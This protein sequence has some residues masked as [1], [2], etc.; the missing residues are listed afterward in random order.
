[1]SGTWRVLI[2]S[3]H[4]LGT[5]SYRMGDHLKLIGHSLQGGDGNDPHLRNLVVEVKSG[6]KM[7]RTQPFSA[8]ASHSDV[9]TLNQA[10]VRMLRFVTM[11]GDGWIMVN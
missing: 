11:G 6:N 10:A 9:I 4:D 2:E 1:M 7:M 3:L 5:A 8:S